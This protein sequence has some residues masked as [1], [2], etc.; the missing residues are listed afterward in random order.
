MSITITYTY[1]A[2]TSL[3]RLKDD[4][5]NVLRGFGSRSSA[6]TVTVDHDGDSEK[7]EA[8]ASYVRQQ[9]RIGISGGR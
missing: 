7:T 1:P 9:G 3:E 6:P 4:I 8:L 5:D 2:G